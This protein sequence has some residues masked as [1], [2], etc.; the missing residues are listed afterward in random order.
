MAPSDKLIAPRHANGP[1]LH[2]QLP[3]CPD[4][5]PRY[6]NSP[7]D[8]PKMAISTGGPHMAPVT[9]NSPD[10][11]IDHKPAQGKAMAK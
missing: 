2:Q 1:R 8:G 11:P 6:N 10:M 5:S 7:M 4:K 9:N 3:E